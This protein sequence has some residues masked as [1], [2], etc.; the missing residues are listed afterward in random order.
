[1]GLYYKDPP[2]ERKKMD[3]NTIADIVASKLDADDLAW[4]GLKFGEM[5]KDGFTIHQP[6][7]DDE[8]DELVRTDV[9]VVKVTEAL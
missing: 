1:V 8:T 2:V 5:I 6:V 9:F 7:F 4:S 3:A